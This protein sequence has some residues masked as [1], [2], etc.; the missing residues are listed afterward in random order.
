MLDMISTR[1]VTPGL[2]APRLNIDKMGIALSFTPTA[3]KKYTY[4]HLRS[5]MHALALESGVSIDMCYTAPSA[6]ITLGRFVGNAFFEE[7]EERKRF[8]GLVEEIN[9][10]LGGN[11]NTWVVGGEQG[12]ELQLG[13]LKFGR[14]REKAD[15]VGQPGS[16]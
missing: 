8:L 9:K 11:E 15:M 4:H 14:A 1:N 7:T 5:D 6:H 10:G 13:Y 3:E 12:L 16:F 2:T